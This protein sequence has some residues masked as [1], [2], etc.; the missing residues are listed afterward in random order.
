MRGP[1]H[2]HQHRDQTGETE[3]NPWEGDTE[4]VPQD[5]G[6]EIHM[7]SQKNPEKVTPGSAVCPI[8]HK[9]RRAPQGQ[10][11]EPLSTGVWGQTSTPRAEHH[12]PAT[13]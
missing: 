4:H 10:I 12:T 2:A 7:G 6:K 8:K 5:V 9:A 11:T 1:Q 3:L 13:H